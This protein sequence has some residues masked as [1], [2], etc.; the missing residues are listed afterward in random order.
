VWMLP[1]SKASTIWRSMPNTG[2]LTTLRCHYRLKS[3]ILLSHLRKLTYLMPRSNLILKRQGSIV[4]PQTSDNQ[5]SPEENLSPRRKVKSL[6]IMLSTLL[7]IKRRLTVFSL[8]V[9]IKEDSWP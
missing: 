6:M 8:R 3:V 4:V 7:Q 2:C 1:S 9:I 5:R